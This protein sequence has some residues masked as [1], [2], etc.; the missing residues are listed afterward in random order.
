MKKI[1]SLALVCVMLVGSMFALV[2]CAKTLSG[3]YEGLLCDL[4]FDGSDVT[5]TVGS[6]SVSGTYEIKEK[7]DGSMTI[8]FDF[9][10]EGDEDKGVIKAIDAILGTDVSFKEEDNT[11]TIAKLFKFTKK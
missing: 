7:D 6:N 8:S 5:A 1:L 3:T 2:S 11:I 9:V 4:T 10:E